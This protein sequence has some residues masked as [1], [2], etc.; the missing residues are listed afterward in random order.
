MLFAVALPE[1]QVAR[2]QRLL[3]HQAQGFCSALEVFPRTFQ[4]QKIPHRGVVQRCLHLACHQL[5]ANLLIAEPD[6]KPK[7]GKNPQYYILVRDPSLQLFPL[8]YRLEE[9]RRTFEG[10]GFLLAP[11]PHPQKAAALAQTPLGVIQHPVFF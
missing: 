3:R 1:L 7:I 6:F 9:T 4:F 5:L 2:H 8:F 10:Q 11:A